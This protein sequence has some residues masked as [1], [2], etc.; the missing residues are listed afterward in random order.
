VP[1]A[2]ANVGSR[3][4]PIRTFG[5]SADHD[6]TAMHAITEA[7]SGTFSFVQD[8]AAIQDSFVRCIG[9]LLS[10]AVQE[11]RLTVTC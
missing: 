10:V 5:F 6:A 3:P 7:T 11:A 9:G 4:G 2:F 1:P 8:Q